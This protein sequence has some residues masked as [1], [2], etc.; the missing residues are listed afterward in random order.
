MSERH[1]NK[2]ML[3]EAV[4]YHCDVLE[5]KIILGEKIVASNVSQFIENNG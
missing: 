1:Y 5:S 3:D 4:N 2:G